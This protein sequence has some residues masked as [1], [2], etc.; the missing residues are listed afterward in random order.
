M[1]HRLGFRKVPLF[2]EGGPGIVVF[3]IIPL[4]SFQSPS[5]AF[6]SPVFQS[7]L[8]LPFSAPVVREEE[9]G[10]REERSRSTSSFPIAKSYWRPSTVEEIIAGGSRGERIT[11]AEGGGA[12]E[13]SPGGA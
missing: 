8:P 1:A 3:L 4:V 9:E 6:F 11:A 2:K 10:E 5:P 7:R 12:L 13:G